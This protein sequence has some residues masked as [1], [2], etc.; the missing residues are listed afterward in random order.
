MLD[1]RKAKL[2]KGFGRICAYFTEKGLGSH[3]LAFFLNFFLIG[4]K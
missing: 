3:I 2:V 4:G 1:Y